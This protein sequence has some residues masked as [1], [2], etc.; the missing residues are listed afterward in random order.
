MVTKENVREYVDRL[1]TFKNKSSFCL[2][3]L[4]AF[5]KE[6]FYTSVILISY[7]LDIYL[8]ISWK[9]AVKPD[10][11]FNKNYPLV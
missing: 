8:A 7:S 6:N 11:I 4:Q 2:N 5:I 9:I 1:D 3:Q 10:M